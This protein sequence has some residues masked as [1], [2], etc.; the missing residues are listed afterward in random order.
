ML[1]EKTPPSRPP[2]PV[3]LP[4]IEGLRGLAMT[5][6]F[7]GHFEGL[8]KSYL[9]AGGVSLRIIEFLGVIGH[10]GVCFFLVLSG[11][12]VYQGYLDN[13]AGYTTFVLRRVRRLY[14]PY[15]AMCALYVVLSFLF[16]AESKIP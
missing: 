2:R 8:F 6:V 12:F 10:Q 16:P 3:R 11:Y 4:A 5:L 9:P 14:P 13:P 15:V 1:T 7:F